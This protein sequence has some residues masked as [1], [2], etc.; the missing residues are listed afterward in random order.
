MSLQVDIGFSID[1]PFVPDLWDSSRIKA[2]F[3]S[4]KLE[5][6]ST[7]KVLAVGGAV[8]HYGGG[9]SHALYPTPSSSSGSSEPVDVNQSFWHDLADDLL[10]PKAFK[11][12]ARDVVPK[13]LLE[14]VKVGRDGN[15]NYTEFVKSILAQ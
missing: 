8:T 9:P 1:Q 2:E 4:S 15:V 7:P 13:E 10:I 12:P 14:G 6:P 11:L 5:E 3:A